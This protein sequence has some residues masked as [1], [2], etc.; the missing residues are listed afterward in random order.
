MRFKAS[1]SSPSVM[2]ARAWMC[3]RAAGV[4]RA[5]KGSA[6]TRATAAASRTK[7]LAVTGGAEEWPPGPVALSTTFRE[8]RS[9]A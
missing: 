6:P 3:S 2:G 7:G 5:G 9:E 8:T 1:P 4:S